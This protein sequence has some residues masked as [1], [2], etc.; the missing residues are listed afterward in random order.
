MDLSE[1][2]WMNKMKQNELQLK[3]LMTVSK[4]KYYML[5]VSFKQVFEQV[6]FETADLSM[7][8]VADSQ[9][10]EDQGRVYKDLRRSDIEKSQAS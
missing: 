6:D 5:K 7:E 3:K 9:T 10:T 2:E 4:S 1:T 8:E